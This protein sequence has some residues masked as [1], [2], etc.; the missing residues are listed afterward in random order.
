MRLN[1]RSWQASATAV[2][3]SWTTSTFTCFTSMT[4]RFRPARPKRSEIRPCCLVNFWQ[5][6]SSKSFGKPRARS[7]TYDAAFLVGYSGC[8][9]VDRV[10]VC[11]FSGCTAASPP[12]T[13]GRHP[14]GVEGKFQCPVFRHQVSRSWGY[15]RAT[16][17]R[18]AAQVIHRDIV[19][20]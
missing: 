18:P 19:D 9:G 11:S 7:E 1:C 2:C 10:E 13:E 5:L 15:K 3:T 8:G 6:N 20:S 12:D 17:F 4:R 16:V 14:T